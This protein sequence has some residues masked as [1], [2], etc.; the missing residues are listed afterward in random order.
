MN[1]TSSVNVKE[2]QTLALKDGR[3]LKQVL[4]SLFML[5]TLISVSQESVPTF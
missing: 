4:V 2:K 3:V 1:L 5:G